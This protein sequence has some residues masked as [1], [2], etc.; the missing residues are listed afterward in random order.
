MRTAISPRLAIRIFLNI[1]ARMSSGNELSTRNQSSLAAFY[2]RVQTACCW[3]TQNSSKVE[4]FLVL[5]R[6]RVDSI[7]PCLHCFL[8]FFYISLEGNPWTCHR[9]RSLAWRP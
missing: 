1:F 6:Q 2:E 8:Q 7:P 5:L 3:Q 4:V 9:K